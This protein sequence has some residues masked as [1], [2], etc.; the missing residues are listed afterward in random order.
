LSARLQFIDRLNGGPGW[1]LLS[2]NNRALAIGPQMYGSP[3]A[4]LAAVRRVVRE[5]PPVLRREA[6]GWKW[7]LPPD[8]EP[9]VLCPQKFARRID[10]DRAFRRLLGA[11]EA[12][13]ANGARR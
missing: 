9:E 3:A 8:V 11:L 2:G 7:E 10:A 12:A 6:N 1:R 13:R 4:Q 5:S